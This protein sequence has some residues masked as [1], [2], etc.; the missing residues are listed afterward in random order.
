MIRLYHKD[1]YWKSNFNNALRYLVSPKEYIAVS[2]TAHCRLNKDMHCDHD[3][4]DRKTLVKILLECRQGK[5]RYT[6]FEVETD[7]KKRYEEILKAVIRTSY[8]R[9]KDIA[10]VVR[11]GVIITSWLQCKGDNH[12]T[13]R[14]KR[15]F[16]KPLDK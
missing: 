8:N 7:Y 13:L 2:T 5:R 15:Y 4:I 11:K 12:A 10:I 6:V 9:D 3:L 14:R 1:V 16:Q